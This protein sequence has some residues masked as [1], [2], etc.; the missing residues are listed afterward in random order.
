[1][2]FCC[3]TQSDGNTSRAIPAACLTHEHLPR[4]IDCRSPRNKAMIPTTTTSC[5]KLVEGV[6]ST[7]LEHRAHASIEGFSQKM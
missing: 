1:M 6:R 5:K 7:F 4:D 3:A 2:F